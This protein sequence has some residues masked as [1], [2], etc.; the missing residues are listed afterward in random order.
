MKI[1][2]K[3]VVAIIVLLLVSA[4]LLLAQ[5]SFSTVKAVKLTAADMELFASEIL[6]PGQQQQLASDAEARKALAKDLKETLAVAQKA[7]QEGYDQRPAIRSLISLA[8]D[9]ALAVEF[10]KKN[11]G[12]KVAEDEVKNFYRLTP[13]AFDEFLELNPQFQQTMQ[14][15]QKEQ[16]KRQYAELRILGNHGREKGLEK[17][18]LTKLKM[19]LGKSQVLDSSYRKDLASNAD[20]LIKD[21]DLEAYYNE[22]ANDFEEVHARHILISTRPLTNTGE[23]ADQKDQKDE[24]ADKKPLSKEEARKKAQSILERVRKGENFVKLAEENSDEPGA[25][26]SGG[27]L[28]YFSHGQMVSAF[29]KAAFSMKTGE[30]S[31]LVETEFGYHIIKVEDHRNAP[32]D[33]QKTRRKITDAIKQKKI[34]ERIEQITNASKVEVADD[35]KVTP[36]QLPEGHVQPGA[37]GKGEQ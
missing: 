1:P 5:R 27:D 35:F 19:L 23:E 20:K 3:A 32:L 30:I 37:P 28:G 16:Y 14:G 17:D 29:D 13:N 33:D 22:H 21:E 36:K 24:K 12:V 25:K 15:P 18:D 8:E 2:T 31:D 9:Q 10:Q 26:Q 34:D 4:L 7:E 11:P 6:P